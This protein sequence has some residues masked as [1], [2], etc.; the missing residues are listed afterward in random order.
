MCVALSESRPD[1]H[2]HE[3]IEAGV[4]LE[5]PEEFLADVYAEG[6]HVEGEKEVAG[7]G[8]FALGAENAE[9]QVHAGV[10]PH[11]RPVEVGETHAGHHGNQ[12]IAVNRRD[13]SVQRVRKTGVLGTL[14]GG[15]DADLAP[16]LHLI[17][18]VDPV[19]PVQVHFNRL[20]AE[21]A[22]EGAEKAD[23]PDAESTGKGERAGVDANLVVQVAVRLLC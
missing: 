15:L 7:T 5:L 19:V 18:V 14:H 13:G 9:T 22:A 10:E 2:F 11:P 8:V 21:G 23:G 16:G 6:R 1:A 3:G 4:Q 20:V 17:I 12:Q